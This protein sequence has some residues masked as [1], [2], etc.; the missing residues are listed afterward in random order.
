MLLTDRRNVNTMPNFLKTW[1]PIIL[2]TIIALIMAF[3]YVNPAPPSTVT[4]ATG[5]AD[6]V[7]YDFAQQYQS[8][9]ANEGF[10]LN[11]VET[12]GSQ[13][14]LAKLKNGEVDVA[15]VQGGV[16]GSTDHD[17]L[18]TLASLFY[19]PV[20]LFHRNTS[21]ELTYLNDLEGLKVAIG[22]AGSGTQLLATKLLEENQINTTNTTLLS[23]STKAAEEALI[24]G[25]I[26]AF[27]TV[28]NASSPLLS[29]LVKE[30][31]IEIL[32]F[33]RALAYSRQLPFLK[34]LT[35]GEGMIS[36]KDN[37]PSQQIELIA[38]TANLVATE[39]L[40]RDLVRVILKAATKVHKSSGIFERTNE[41]PNNLYVDIPMDP[42]ADLYLQSGD[43]WLERMLP[44]SVASNIKRLIII[45]LP[46]L[47]LLI[48]LTKGALPLYRWR[49]RFKIFKWYEV[50]KEV[51][52]RVTQLK[53]DE[54]NEE[55]ARVTK[56]L[57]E[58]KDQTDV[59]L[60]YMGEY[61]DLQLHINLV[62]EKLERVAEKRL[63]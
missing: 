23:L 28:L 41:F 38:A 8:L 16:A 49:I 3:R 52:S 54:I 36:L 11:I 31:S 26:D 6:G 37:I 10:T 47:T 9:L 14:A 12:A 60:S 35:I 2:L 30:P 44:F 27:I 39:D 61:Y 21:T 15:F 42:D 25:E 22:E 55:I 63:Q 7:Y 13:A 59:P 29:E 53:D 19:E 48:P 51:D 46:L 32:S 43:T 40:H 45:L 62:L 34:P 24:A 18:T 50:L 56:L 58:V 5:R 17:N 20:W 4:I 1:I 57:Y 33:K